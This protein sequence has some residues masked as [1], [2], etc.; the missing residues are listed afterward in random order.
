MLKVSVN[1]MKPTKAEHVVIYRDNIPVAV[2]YSLDGD[3]VVFADGAR[4]ND[5][6]Q[7]LQNLGVKFDVLPTPG[8]PITGDM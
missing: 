5:F 2:A 4:D 8:A 7:I 1:N 3:N 6:G